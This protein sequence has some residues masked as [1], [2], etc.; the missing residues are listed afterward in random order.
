MQDME[1]IGELDTI[2]EAI[3]LIK[4]HDTPTGDTNKDL[5]E[6]AV[7]ESV[8]SALATMHKRRTKDLHPRLTSL[9]E[10]FLNGVM[11]NLPHAAADTPPTIVK[12]DQANDSSQG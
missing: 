9:V 7:K 12:A 4:F 3:R 1:L 6:N 11:S 2:R 10:G 5:V 8:V